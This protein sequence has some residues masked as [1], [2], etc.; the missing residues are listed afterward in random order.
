M[1]L[2]LPYSDM[3]K[4]VFFWAQ[5]LAQITYYNFSSFSVWSIVGGVP[6]HGGA[7][8]LNVAACFSLRVLLRAYNPYI[9]QETK[10]VSFYDKS[11]GCKESRSPKWANTWAGA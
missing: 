10:A 4:F 11:T 7:A 9:V 3:R 6:F 5:I 1:H 2:K 8:A